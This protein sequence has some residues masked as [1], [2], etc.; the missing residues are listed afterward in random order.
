MDS[1]GNE[2]LI[3]ASFLY[4]VVLR[5]RGEH[6]VDAD[7]RLS[8]TSYRR[9]EATP[10]G[11]AIC[12][13]C[14]LMLTVAVL[15]AMFGSNVSAIVAALSV[16]TVPDGAVTLTVRRTVHVV[17]GAMLLFSWQMICPVPRY[18]GCV[19]VPSPGVPEMRM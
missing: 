10:R 16:I 17:F 19:H 3:I 9:V 8:A 13:Y 1:D 14:T 6:K 7:V 12:V 15:L 18:G 4:R 2:Q 11:S 5:A